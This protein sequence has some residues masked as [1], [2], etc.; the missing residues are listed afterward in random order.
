MGIHLQT[1]VCRDLYRETCHLSSGIWLRQA[2]YC[3]T[4]YGSLE[5]RCACV[6]RIYCVLDTGLWALPRVC[7]Q[8]LKVSSSVSPVVMYGCES[9]TIRKAER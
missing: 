5:I 6:L 7:S 2:E 1:S 8:G 4:Q 9:W 3:G